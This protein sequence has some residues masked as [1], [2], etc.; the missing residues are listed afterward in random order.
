[1]RSTKILFNNRLNSLLVLAVLAGAVVAL[2]LADIQ[3]L[4]HNHYLQ[5]AEQNRTQILYQTAP[6]GRILTAD[7][8][9]VAKS[10]FISNVSF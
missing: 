8:K 2:R 9:A 5:L 7:G 1:M 10:C 4:R 3:L 6:R